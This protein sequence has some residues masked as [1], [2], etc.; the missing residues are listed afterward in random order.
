MFDLFE[1]YRDNIAEWLPEMLDAC[2]GT[3]KLTF[4]SFFLAAAVGLL[5]SLLRTSSSR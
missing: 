3:L 1:A 2:G 5:F 4:F